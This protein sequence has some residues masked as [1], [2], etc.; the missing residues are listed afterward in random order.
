MR[1]GEWE[2]MLTQ[3]EEWEGLGWGIAVRPMRAHGRYHMQELI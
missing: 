1:M 2:C 3:D